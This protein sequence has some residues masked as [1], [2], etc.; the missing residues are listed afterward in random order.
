MPH[1]SNSKAV[2]I[3]SVS[4]CRVPVRGSAGRPGEEERWVPASVGTAVSRSG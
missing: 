3:G 2:Q 4:M 1:P